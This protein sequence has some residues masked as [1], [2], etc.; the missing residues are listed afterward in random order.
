ML[1]VYLD[2]DGVLA[3]FDKKTIE[4]I[5]K[6]LREFPTSKEGWDAMA[7]HRNIYELL[8]PMPDAVELVNG[9]ITLCKVHN[10][11]YGVL[12][13]IPKIGKIPDAKIHKVKWIKNTFPELSHNFN[14]GPHAQHKQFHARE[15]DVLIDDSELNIPQWNDAGGYGILHTSAKRSLVL[16]ENYLVN[17]RFYGIQAALASRDSRNK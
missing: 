8:E 7:D 17:V 11:N 16:L 12:T 15:G 10:V 1:T 14:I 13:A 3:D 5:G 4:L 2:M 6:M 9:V